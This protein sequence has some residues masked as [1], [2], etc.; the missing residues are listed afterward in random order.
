M[1]EQQVLDFEQRVEFMY[2]ARNSSYEL[3]REARIQLNHELFV[4]WR[5]W[6]ACRNTS[7]VLPSNHSVSLGFLE[8]I[9]HEKASEQG[10]LLT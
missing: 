7:R 4:H 3:S 8:W 2:A 10:Q 5:Q 6:Y 1:T 9:C